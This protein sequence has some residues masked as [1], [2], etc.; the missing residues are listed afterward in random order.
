[1]LLTL[2]DL[3]LNLGHNKKTTCS[4]VQR[5]VVDKSPEAVAPLMVFSLFTGG[6][7]GRHEDTTRVVCFRRHWR[8]EW[9]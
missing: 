2:R 4:V 7:T 1:M 9:V 8:V 5:T 6:T 3:W